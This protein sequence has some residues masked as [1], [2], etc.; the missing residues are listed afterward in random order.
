MRP[1][2]ELTLIAALTL[3]GCT[4]APR[5]ALSPDRQRF[6][7]KAFSG[8]G[9]AGG[10]AAAAAPAL[11]EARS[12][13]AAATGNAAMFPRSSIANMVIRTGQAS[14]EVDSLERAVAEVRL[15]AG[16]VGGYI[17]NTTMQ[18]G[19]REL[20]SARLE[21]KLPADRFDDGL[22]GLATIGK[23]ESVN[24][25]AEDV[26]EE[27]TDVTAR[28]ANAR[29]L[30]SRLI[31]LLATRTGK[32]KDVLDVEQELARVREEIERYEGRL[33]YLR[34]HAALSTLTIDVHEPIPVVGR[35]GSSVMGEAFKQAWR[36]F[37]GL[38]ALCIRSLGVLIPLALLALSAWFGIQRWRK[39]ALSAT[40]P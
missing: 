1:I 38:L 8:V 26:G 34:A 24:I 11:T 4:T 12:S 7:P 29:R 32:L 33:R 5:R 3:A 14:L 21:V 31:D 27:F 23:I 15:L 6:D 37:M 10:F 36:N 22:G 13:A 20:R 16:R 35:A 28:M 18:T 39:S 17:A 40:R 9:V 19:R 25:T 2:G 30:E